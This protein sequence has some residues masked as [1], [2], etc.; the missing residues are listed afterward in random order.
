MLACRTGTLN[1]LL[2]KEQT[3]HTHTQLVSTTTR[4][5]GGRKVESCMKKSH[6]RKKERETYINVK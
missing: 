3:T 1:N 4:K 2:F 5:K 6:E